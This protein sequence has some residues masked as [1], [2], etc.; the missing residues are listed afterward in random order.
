MTPLLQL[1]KM[2]SI[3]DSCYKQHAVIEFLIA[4]KEAVENIP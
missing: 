3:S 4:V 1:F 2:E